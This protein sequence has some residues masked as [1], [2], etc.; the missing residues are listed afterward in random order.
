MTHRIGTVQPQSPAV[1]VGPGRGSQ[2]APGHWQVTFAPP[3][4]AS[5]TKF[6]MLHFTAAALGAGDRIEI[7]LG[8]DTDTFTAADGPSFWSRPVPGNN[9]T[10]VFVDGGGGAGQASLSEFGRGEGLVN[11]GTDAAVG[12]NA[13]GDVFMTDGGWTDPTF[14]NPAGI[15]P[16]TTSPSWENVETLLPGLMRNTARSVGMFVEATGGN[17]STCSAALIG[18]DLILT[19]GHCVGGNN[20]AVVTGSFTLD[21][22]TDAAGG[23]PAGYNPRFHKLKRLVKSG[24]TV[25]GVGAGV[26]TGTGLDYA[27]IQI[28]TP[29]GGLGVPPLSIRATTVVGDEALFVIHHP[30]GTAKKISRQPVDAKCKVISISTDGT[31]I[32]YGCDSD[33]GSSGSPVFD[34][35]GRIV[36]VNDW[37]PG[38]CSNQGQSAAEILLDLAK[39]VPAPVD[40]NA[41][42]VLDRSGSMSELGFTGAKTKI[43]EAREAAALFVDLLRTDQTHRVG[44]AT[45]SSGSSLDFGVAPVSPANKNTLIG[46]PSN[47]NAGL[48]AAVTPGGST[49]IGGGLDRGRNALAA[50]GPSPNMPAI[51]L[52]TDG[53]ENTPPTIAD[54]EPTLG[55]TRLCIIGFGS[56]GSV[57]GPR[58][59][60]LA[61]DHGGI[62]TRAGEGL[63]LKKFFVLAFGNIFQTAVSMDPLM[64]M[65][66]GVAKVPALPLQV[67]GEEVITVVLSWEHASELLLLSLETPGGSTVTPTTPGVTASSGDTWV[68]IRIALPFAGERDGTW[69]VNVGRSAGGGEFPAP[70]PQE[71]FFVTVNVEGGP[72][73]R[74]AGPRRYYTGDTINPQV[75]LRYPE[76]G[77]V[78]AKVTVDIDLPQEGTGNI[79]TQTG[80]RPA[81]EIDGDQLDARAS[82]LI[83]LEKERGP[84]VPVTT[85]VFELVDEGD[86]DGDWALEPNGVYGKPLKDLSRYEGSYTF[87]AKAA[88]GDGCGGTRETTWTLYVAVGVDPGKT[89]VTS[90]SLGTGPDG[91]EQVVLTFTPRDRYGSYVGPGRAG[92][93]EVVP[94]PGTRPQGP[95][96]DL[97]NGSYQVDVTWDPESADPPRVGIGQP[98]RPPVVIGPSEGRRWVYGVKFLCGEQR[99]DC[100][101]CAPVRPGQ[102][103]TEINIH[104]FHDREVP[105]AK[106]VLPLVLAGAVRAREPRVTGP[107]AKDKIVLPPHGA[108]MDDCCRLLELLLG[109]RPA[110]PTPLTI[111]ILEIT[112]P[113]ELNV[114]AVYTV[115]DLGGHG[116]S[117]DVRVIPAHRTG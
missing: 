43:A 116:S 112:S 95:V 81:V 62:Y 109:A 66:A 77:D 83:A 42:L 89:E 35:L 90:T 51:L 73:F 24:F 72:I 52:L 2:V 6:L 103:A 7:S 46:P 10:I 70:L 27:V 71:R 31:V 76:G 55:N 57:D 39:P 84:L 80:L 61:R 47:R 28:E 17:V 63:Q 53:L 114:T 102:Y 93:L 45:F 8:Y 115:T 38:S 15:C 91:R 111:G 49:T 86:E 54:V 11:G 98:E 99:E 113:V 100:G 5:G 20:E 74:P 69:L 25:A 92:D 85:T 36:A 56:E 14:F 101:T 3:A 33:N 94:L 48:I 4:A 19:A 18:P 104:N 30:R 16:A 44:L 106:R 117:M 41:V 21:F 110:G 82:T 108:T 12:G 13:N 32:T 96:R 88:Y 34:A 67:C 26:S 40:V 64:V 68:Y 22:Q 37:A 50:V 23:K 1:V 58:L 105:V 29:P 59:T 87:H 9:A 75:V 78:G 79:L 97:G 107:A 65:P 60:G